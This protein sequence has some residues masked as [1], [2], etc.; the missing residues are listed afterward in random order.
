MIYQN[1]NVCHSFRVSVLI[2]AW[3]TQHIFLECFPYK[4][5]TENHTDHDFVLLAIV[6]IKPVSTFCNV[7]R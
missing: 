2:K 1:L 5:Y 4:T 3:N 6:E 7:I